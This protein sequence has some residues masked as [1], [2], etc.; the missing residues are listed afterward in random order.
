[1]KLLLTLLL[2]FAT[3]P[4]ANACRGPESE[5][6]QERDAVVK[7][8]G[9]A[10]AYQMQTLIGHALITFKVSKTLRGESRQIWPLYFRSKSLPTN[11][12]EFQKRF[13]HVSEV[14]LREMIAPGERSDSTRKA[15][16]IVDAAC[17]MN[18]EDWLLRKV[19][20][21]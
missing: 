21:K 11:L 3:S 13:G 17:S 12:A 15:F 7:F 10:T 9:T 4:I 20:M 14:G 1:M 5:R 18:G 19:E 6:A 2:V 8:V 16:Y